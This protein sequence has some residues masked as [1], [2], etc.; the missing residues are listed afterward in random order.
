MLHPSKHSLTTSGQPV[1]YCWGTLNTIDSILDVKPSH[2]GRGIGRNF[3]E[4]LLDESLAQREPLLLIT[5]APESSE[6]FW[7][8]M[9]FTTQRRDS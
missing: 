4:H 9:G 8:R 1:A 2:R 5:C 6:G 3:V 7:I